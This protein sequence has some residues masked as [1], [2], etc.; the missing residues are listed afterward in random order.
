M[1]QE[2]AMGAQLVPHGPRGR[3]PRRIYLG[4]G[5]CCHCHVRINRGCSPTP[6]FL[7]QRCFTT[8]GP[9]KVI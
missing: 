4:G 8:T 9:V 5:R 7:G 3:G 6:T 2:E 1:V